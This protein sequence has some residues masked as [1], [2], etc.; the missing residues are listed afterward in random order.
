MNGIESCAR[1]GVPLMA[2]GGHRWEGNGVITLAMSPRNRM[3][4]YESENI[5]NLFGGIKE[6]LGIPIEHMV[7]ESRRRE[8]RR[9]MER[10]YSGSLREASEKTR[11]GMRDGNLPLDSAEELRIAE[12]A[13]EL[14]VNVNNIGRAYGYG[15]ISLGEG[16]ETGEHYPWRTQIIRHP[17]SLPLYAA[18][19]LGS[20]E[21]VEGR[22]LRV[23]YEEIGEG[24]YRVTSFP[25]S[26]PIE[27]TERL[28]RQKYDFKPGDIQYE[29]CPLCGIPEEVYRCR[30]DLDA[31]T[32]TDLESG[33][34]MAIFGPGSLDAILGDLEAELGEAIPEAVISAQKHYIKEHMKEESW[35]KDALSFRR[36]IASRGLGN[37][38]RFEG[39]RKSLEVT[40]ENACLH[41]LMVGTTQAMVEIVYGTED[42]ACEWELAD[43][44]DLRIRISL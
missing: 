16:W 43:D 20:V 14:N 19:M 33:R 39:D 42:L 7:I 3:V 23:E 41:L 22:D 2:S 27:L 5:D 36:L 21:A 11:E 44:G 13:R 15:D 8:T 17:Y 28:Q 26:H 29:R 40:L 1:C 9:Y 18:D 4:F 31:G 32:I 6:L 38:N 34:R 30:W 24:T 25:G 37:L 12:A 35:K 10:I